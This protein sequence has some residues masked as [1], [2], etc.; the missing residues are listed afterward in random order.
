MSLKNKH[1]M[2]SCVVT[3]GGQPSNCLWSQ[4]EAL[5][6]PSYAIAVS[7]VFQRLTVGEDYYIV[8]NEFA[9]DYVG[10]LLVLVLR[11][12]GTKKL[13]SLFAK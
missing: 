7:A 2:S 1:E 10:G 8:A 12:T 3:T 13:A 6:I 4:W 9:R 11:P 5:G